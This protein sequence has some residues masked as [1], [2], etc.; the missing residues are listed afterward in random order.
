MTKDGIREK[1]ENDLRK[2]YSV[3]LDEPV[4]QDMLDLIAQLNGLA[5]H[6]RVGGGGAVP[7]DGY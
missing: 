7:R 2:L 3:V 6:R 5:V 1:V 4:P